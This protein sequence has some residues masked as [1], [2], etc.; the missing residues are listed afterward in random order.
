MRQPLGKDVKNMNREEMITRSER[1]DTDNDLDL[2]GILL[3]ISSVTRRLAKLVLDA[4]A[5]E[6]K[7]EKRYE[8][9][10]RGSN[11]TPLLL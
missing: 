4:A 11:R 1:W 7:G 8:Y 10:H 9:P 5:Q 2:A 3:T 6:E